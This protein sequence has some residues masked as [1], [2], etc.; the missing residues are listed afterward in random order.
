V[1]VPEYAKLLRGDNR[2]VP[3]PVWMAEQILG[4][5]E[6][7]KTSDSFP[8]LPCFMAEESGIIDDFTKLILD[9]VSPSNNELKKLAE[10]HKPPQEWY[11]QDEDLFGDHLDERV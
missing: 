7:Y 8:K 9:T 1:D 10:T 6:K 2:P 11:D 4:M 5:L 3:L